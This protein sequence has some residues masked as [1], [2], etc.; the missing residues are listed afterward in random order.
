MYSKILLN[1][2]LLPFFFASLSGIA[3][4]KS[5]DSTD[6][7]FILGDL[8]VQ[9]VDGFDAR[10]L[11]KEFPA[12][13]NFRME[14]EISKPTNIWLA[15]FD[16]NQVT[17][18][19]IINQL[20]NSRYV[21]AAQKN[22]EV[23]MRSVT[24]NDP[25]FNQQWHHV[26]TGQTGGTPDADIDSDLAWEVTTGGQ[27]A[28]GDD[29]VVC[30]I[31]SADL[32]HNDLNGN[33]WVNIYESATPNGQDDDGNGYV[34]D[35]FGW[36]IQS[37][38]DDIGTGGHGTSVAGMIGAVGDNDLGVV[39]ANWDV[40]L[41]VVAGH[42]T[43]EAAVIEAYTYPLTMRQLYNDTDGDQGAFVVAT[44]ASWGIDGGDPEDSP[45][46]CDFYET[47]GEVGILNCGATT[48]SNLNVDD[49]GDLPTGCPSDYM[50]GVGRT[51]HNDNF[52]GGYGPTTIDLASPGIDVVTT[53]SNNGYTTTTGTS[54]ASPLTAG[55][56]GL[57][58]SVPCPSLI[59]L[60]K[61]D[62]QQGADIIREALLNGVDQKPQLEDYF[63]TGG[64]LNAN[65]AVQYLL[66]NYCSASTCLTPMSITESGVTD[67]EA[68]ISW[69]EFGAEDEWEFNF[70]LLGETTWETD[71]ITTSS[72][73][74]DTLT[75]C[76]DYEYYIIAVC[77]DE[78]SEPTDTLI[79][80][81]DGCCESP[82]NTDF[83]VS[84]SS[85]TTA[86][87]EWVSV[88]AAN[89]YNVRYR[90]IGAPDWIEETDVMDNSFAISGLSSCTEYEIQVQVVCDSETPDYSDSFVF[91][92]LGCDVCTELVY[93][94]SFGSTTE[95]E[96]IETIT[97]HDYTN[98]S[99]DDGG[100]GDYTGDIATTL[101]L[102]ETYN[103]SLTPGFS[104]QD[105]D[106]YFR[107]WIDLN[108]DGEFTAD[109]LVYDAGQATTVTI[110][111]EIEIPETAFTGVTRMRISM[112]YYGGWTPA[113]PSPCE[114]FDFG[115]VED[116]CV[117]ITT[118][119]EYTVTE[120]ISDASCNGVE[121]GM[122]ELEVLNAEEPVTFLWNTGGETAMIDNL[123]AGTYEVTVTDGD[124]CSTVHE[125]IVGTE[126][127]LA[128]DFTSEAPSCL[129]DE[130]G[131]IT[132][133][134]TQGTEDYIYNWEDG[135]QDND[136]YSNIVAGD[137]TVTVTDNDGCTATET[138]T[139]EDGT[140]V[141]VNFTSTTPSCL[142]GDDGSITAEGMDGEGPYTYDWET[143]PETETYNDVS[144]GDYTVTVTDNNGCSTVATGTV[145]DG[146]EITV[147]F[148]ST[149]PS[150]ID[151]ND[152]SITAEGQNGE[153]PYTYDW[154]NGPETQTYSDV[155]AGDYTVTV[156]DANGCEGSGTGTVTDP[157]ADIADFTIDQDGP[158]VSFNNNSTPG[159]YA[160]DFD[161][162]N[163]STE[164]NP[165][166]TYEENGLY[167]VCLTVTTDCGSTT[168]CDEV[169]V[170]TVG[171]NQYLANQI[172][173]YPN[174]ASSQVFFEIN[175]KEAAMI[176]LYDISGR[177]VMTKAVTSTISDIDV[178]ALSNGTYIYHVKNNEGTSIYIDKININR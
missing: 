126:Y 77:P 19:E 162:G 83:A 152:G 111:G 154:V 64:R 53:S 173:V 109:E 128:V 33:R 131:S 110:T 49:A 5:N 72:I 88:L 37:N 4:N 80:S 149:S 8:L 13:Y 76:T 47:L 55:V 59:A 144:A 12:E 99:G 31:E 36:N 178:N 14:R 81:T 44:N 66:D 45:L 42:S 117:E 112:K 163:T 65:N 50:I 30:I 153:A 48:N 87:V 11:E 116:Y 57:L 98:D 75:A 157:D 23:E 107:I 41:M 132:A 139:V 20:Y 174:P 166:H 159:G 151:D 140:E 86:T 58:Y 155:S 136:T 40:K 108:Q 10:Q 147:A 146:E 106:E 60:V 18:H 168:H 7:N 171:I 34:D 101:L 118:P 61:A 54:F 105:W 161:D 113:A 127:E 43:Q 51:D 130:D 16:F 125:F 32:S 52:A 90:E 158:T 92:T 68:T 124:E 84:N 160:W 143:G 148:T 94:E 39:G 138:G 82:G 93:C 89:S 135:P 145:A 177:I 119:C 170:T 21:K 67:T 176:Q 26:N 17:H 134:A 62:P 15:K 35:Y 73:T 70:R 141:S 150:C 22:H 96:W 9:V 69:T 2:L 122:I 120:T 27:T 95:D 142:G 63:I 85:E 102:G 100:Y 133:I 1:L 103:V 167:E 28:L 46:W 156:T 74:I 78:N 71:I 24:P 172:K 123:A 6:P 29:I 25:Q 165:T 115:E 169:E 38:D 104:G 175:T 97:V 129:G 137:Y 114:E 79:L 91:S 164:T 56:I 121:N 3:Q